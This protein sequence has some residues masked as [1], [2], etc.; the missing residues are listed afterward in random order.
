MYTL[1]IILNLGEL[2]VLICTKREKGIEGKEGGERTGEEGRIE[3][4][5]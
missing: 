3:D 4:R 5:T 1:A 2:P